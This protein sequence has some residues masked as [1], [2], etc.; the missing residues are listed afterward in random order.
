MTMPDVETVCVGWA[1]ADSTLDSIHG[2]RVATRLPKE[3]ETN[4]VVV[5]IVDGSLSVAESGDIVSAIVQW[6]AYAKSATPSPNYAGAWSLVAAIVGRLVEASDVVVTGKGQICA[7]GGVS[8]PRRLD[9]P[10][11]RWARFSADVPIV[12]RP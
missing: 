10:Q 11:T 5:T 1:K 2:G 9:D 6:D 8:G 12:V 7:S 4:F 3:W